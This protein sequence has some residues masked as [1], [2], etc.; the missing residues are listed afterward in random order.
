MWEANRG[1]P[2][3]AAPP[4]APPTAHPAWLP[5]PRTTRP[6]PGTTQAPPPPPRL[7][8]LPPHIGKRGPFRMVRGSRRRHPLARPR[9]I[10]GLRQR[11]LVPVVLDAEVVGRRG[12]DHVPAVSGEVTKNVTAI[13]QKEAADR[14]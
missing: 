13:G 10:V 2:G 1:S 3:R 6:P 7:P 11:V 9:E 8:R 4:P 14:K 12:D 5:Q